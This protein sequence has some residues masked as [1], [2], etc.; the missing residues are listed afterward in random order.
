MEGEML[1]T[2]AEQIRGRQWDN[3]ISFS[4]FFLPS[5]FFFFFFFFYFPLS[6]PPPPRLRV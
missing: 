3:S 5:I 2:R 1:G 6:T 4:S